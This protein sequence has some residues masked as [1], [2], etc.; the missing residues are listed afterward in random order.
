MTRLEFID[1]MTDIRDEYLNE[2][3]SRLEAPAKKALR[4]RLAARRVLAGLAA[5]ILLFVCGFAVA[6][7]A[8]P[9][10]REL[11]ASLIARK[12]QTADSAAWRP[13]NVVGAC[14]LETDQRLFILENRKIYAAPHGSDV[15]SVLC[16]KPGCGH[17]DES[18]DAYGG[19]AIG[20]YQGKIYA[21]TMD[22]N[23]VRLQRMEPDGSDHAVVCDLPCLPRADGSIGGYDFFCF[24]EGFLYYMCTP[25]PYPAAGASDQ[26][27]S[28][29]LFR[30][31]LLTGETDEP[32]KD[33]LPAG[34]N[35]S[36]ICQFE[37]GKWYMQA[38][39][40]EDGETKSAIFRADP[41]A[42]TLRP[43]LDN[44]GGRRAMGWTVLGN[45]ILYY[46][47]G[48]G[49]VRRDW[50]SGQESLLLE[51]PGWEDAECFF[52]VDDIYLSRKA[53]EK[54][55]RLFS[56]YSW[57]FEPLGSLSLP[58]HYQ[59]VT[60]TADSVYFGVIDWGY[61][62]KGCLDKNE[63]GAGELSLRPV[64]YFNR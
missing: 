59:Y 45:S 41:S 18:C 39:Y 44:H 32:W 48:R 21:V 13:Q 31:D 25:S 20:W 49:I 62:L 56:V 38:D 16:E 5:A 53:P 47:P 2:A 46:E 14:C 51:D 26:T 11:T 9:A 1:A 12:Q 34:M 50:E 60:E 64:T 3:R 22:M 42:G 19:I 6:L 28:A 37:D 27:Q 43:I 58:A 40:A 55:Q 7:A 4:G 15:F 36:Q 33:S 61:C 10:L 30:T 24:C 35:A 8:S 57:D 54:G 29:A 52:G 17:S 63:I 23:G